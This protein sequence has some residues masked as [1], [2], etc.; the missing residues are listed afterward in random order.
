MACKLVSSVKPLILIIEEAKFM[1]IE[2]DY[3]IKDYKKARK[4]YQAYIKEFPFGEYT[5]NSYARLQ[6]MSEQ[7]MGI[8]E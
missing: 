5:G 6:K 4:G 8:S 1:L 3:S 2:I 7:N